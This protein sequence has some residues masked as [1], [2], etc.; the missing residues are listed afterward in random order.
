MIVENTKYYCDY[1]NK[2]IKEEE[3]R[4]GAKVELVIDLQNPKI[5]MCGER[6]ATSLKLCYDCS[7]SIGII[8]NEEYHS[9]NYS[10]SR[11]K[12]LLEN[13]KKN[14]LSLFIKK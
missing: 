1:C 6:S 8:N 3:Y 2:E 5:G 10:H 14:F 13:N 11:L 4:L 12:K 9:Y 7:K